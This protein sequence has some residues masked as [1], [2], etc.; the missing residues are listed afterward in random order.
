MKTF[1]N[2]VSLTLASLL[3]LGGNVFAQS[4]ADLVAAALNHPDRPDGDSAD[5]AR[6]M[7]LEVL[8]FAGIESGMTVVEMEAAGGYYTEII[9]R[10]VGPDGSVIMQT[11]QAF[12]GFLGDAI[13]V[14][15][16][17]NRL[18]NVT[19]SRTN[20]DTLEAESGSVDMVTWI[21]GPHELWFY[22]AEN[23]D[24]GDP[25]ATFAE[26]YRVLKPGGV[27]LALDHDA[28]PDAP[29]EIGG[30]LHRIPGGTITELA[31]N[32]GLTVI[33]SS[34]MHVNENDP[35]DNNVFD[36]SIQGRTSKFVILYQK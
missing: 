3:L 27:F 26:I 10:A 32:A 22:P 25:E 13:D 34:N 21:L 28:M 15:T 18:P 30:T 19:V 35:L 36:P 33:R 16:A 29:N 7:P 4:S 31:E 12:D 23:V 2:T 5:D 14:R 20:F 1:R 24:F 11:P 9:S 6:R 8:A 17:N